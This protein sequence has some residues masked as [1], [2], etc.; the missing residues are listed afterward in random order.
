MRNFARSY[1]DDNPLYSTDGLRRDDPLG[2]PDRPADDPDR[3][4]PAAATGSAE[5]SASSARRSAASTCSS[6]AAPGTGTGRSSSRRR[7]LQLRRD[8]VGRREEVGVRRTLGPRQLASVK[9]NQRGEI[10]AISRTLADPHRAQDRPGEGQVRGDRAG[11]LHR[12]GHRRDRR[13][14]RRRARRGREPRW[15]EDVEVGDVL[16]PMAKGP[17]TDDRHDRVPRRRLRV[18]PVRPVL[19]PDRLQEPAAHRAVLRQERARRPRRRAAGALGLGVGP[20]DRQPDGLRLRGDARLPAVALRH[21]LD[22][23][24]RLARAAE[25]ARSASSTTSA[26]PT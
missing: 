20:G 13:D 4:E 6:R 22:G 12:R 5:P 7:A 17:L 10:V 1:G 16:P 8:R 11:H 15:W 24:R 25:L 3:A 9:I 14:L 2:R 23:R 21:R 19:E 26:T 18:R